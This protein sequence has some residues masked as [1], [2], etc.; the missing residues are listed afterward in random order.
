MPVQPHDVLVARK[1]AD[2]HHERGLGQ[3]EVGDQQ[4]GHLELEAR[5]NE[6]FRV[7]TGLPRLCPGLQRADGGGADGDDAATPGLGLGDSLLRGG[8]HLVPLAVHAVFGQVF[9]L[10]G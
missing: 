4:V 9:G 8:G 5:G 1:G 10:H 2:E 3:M 6:D 7:A